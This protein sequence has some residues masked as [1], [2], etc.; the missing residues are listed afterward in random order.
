MFDEIVNKLGFGGEIRPQKYRYTV[1]GVNG[2]IFEG[3]KKVV[4]LTDKEITLCVKGGILSVTGEKL[5]RLLFFL[6]DL[7]YNKGAIADGKRP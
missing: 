4:E 5:K 7:R 1:F 3:V 6:E 2:G